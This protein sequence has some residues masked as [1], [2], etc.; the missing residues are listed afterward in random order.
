MKAIA[1]NI[2]YA[3]LFLSQVFACSNAPKN[4]LTLKLQSSIMQYYSGLNASDFSKIATSISD[5][6]LYKEMDF[7][8]A[9][10]K[11]DFYENFRWDSVFKP[12]YSIVKIDTVNEHIFKV[13]VAKICNRIKYLH[14]T[15]IVF[16]QVFELENNYISTIT[17]TDFLVFDVA[18]WESQ[19]DTLVNW[20]KVNHP[21]LDGFIYD[22]TAKG[23]QNYLKAIDLYKSR[24]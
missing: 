5:S 8:I 18:K 20:I 4:E 22:V 21:E 19:R 12:H 6:I 14:D 23:A 16:K 13:D 3:V 9:D 2:F 10:N 24:N 7:T 15:A 17:T 11:A 1:K